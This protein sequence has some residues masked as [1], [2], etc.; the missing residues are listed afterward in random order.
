MA[1]I[2]GLERG[3]AERGAGVAGVWGSE[4]ALAAVAGGGAEAGSPAAPLGIAVHPAIRKSSAAPR[5]NPKNSLIDTLSL[6]TGIINCINDT[7]ST[8]KLLA[9]LQKDDE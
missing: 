7:V 2:G 6:P 4:L 8:R 9:V 3:S 1:L 5:Q